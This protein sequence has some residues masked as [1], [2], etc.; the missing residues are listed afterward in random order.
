MKNLHRLF[1]VASAALFIVCSPVLAQWQ[2]P[3]NAVPIGRGA[4]TGFKSA[5]PGASGTCLKGNGAS[6][7]TF[8]TCDSVSSLAGLGTGVATAL[9]VNVGSAG[10]F[11]VNGGALGT[12][13]SAILT[14]ATGLPLSTGVT[15]NLPVTNLNSGTGA[16]ASTF[17]RGDGTWATP[18]GGGSGTVVPPQMRITLAPGVAVMTS[19][20]S[21]A[22]TVY[23]T[24]ANGNL[25]PIYNGSSYTMTAFAEVSQLTTDATKSPAAATTNSNYD[26]FCWIDTGPTNRCTRGPPWSSNT[27]RGTGAGT[28]ELVLVNGIYL[29]ANAITNGPSAQRGTFMGSIRTNGTSTVDYSVGG[30]ANGGVAGS[31][32]VW[33]MYNRNLAVAQSIDNTSYTYSSATIRQAHGSV[34]NQ[35]S[36]LVGLAVDIINVSFS[37][38]IVTTAIVSSNSF[39]GI[40]EDSTTASAG[41]PTVTVQTP[42]AG[43][44][45]ATP[46]ATLS[47]VPLL[48][49]HTYAAIESGDNSNANTFASGGAV[50]SLSVWN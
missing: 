24:P 43:A 27:S 15:G 14:N 36:V 33:N 44:L 46:T 2:V 20:V 35:V 5:G 19:T 40:G 10:A 26:V 31:L 16:S 11:V 13:S 49:F 37:T 1:A 21:A 17:W 22:N 8:Q 50:T 47:K 30:T 39:I 45:V 38:R 42:A 32:G 7:P 48:G 18:A 12:P 9:G 29:N 34:G 4:G 6:P 3:D 28:S 23:V 25:V 41:A